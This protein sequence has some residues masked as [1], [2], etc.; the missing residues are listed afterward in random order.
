LTQRELLGLHA[1]VKVLQDQYGISYKDAAHRLYHAEILKVSGL[2]DCEAALSDI[3]TG[4]DAVIVDEVKKGEKDV[5]EE[6]G[7]SADKMAF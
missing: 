5:A 4:L 3:H 6:H 2:A 7:G 1:E